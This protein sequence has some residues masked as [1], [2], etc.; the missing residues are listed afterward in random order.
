M[1]KIKHQ[2]ATVWSGGTEFISSVN[3]HHIR[4]D[5]GKNAPLDTWPSPKRL[6]LTSLAGCTGIDV[7]ELLHKMRVKFTGLEMEVEADLTDEHPK[8]YSE[9]R[10]IYKISGEN[11]DRKKVEKAVNL[12]QEKYCGVTAMLRKNCPIVYTIKYSDKES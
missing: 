8:V 3:R 7:V 11:I 10:L 2:V 4:I 6:L 9:I 1:S 5:T 12:S